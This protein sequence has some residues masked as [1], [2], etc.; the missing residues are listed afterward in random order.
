MFPSLHATPL[1][2]T[3]RVATMGEL[4]LF[5]NPLRQDHWQPP[6]AYEIQT[7]IALRPAETKPL[8]PDPR[9]SLGGLRLRT[10][11]SRVSQSDFWAKGEVRRNGRAPGDVV[12]K[13]DSDPSAICLRCTHRTTTRNGRTALTANPPS[14]REPTSS[15]PPT[16]A[17]RSCIPVVP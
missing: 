15:E 14:A 12:G 4:F 7:P 6:R 9:C 10:E 16:D 17:A 3:T 2:V 11:L 13:Q 1:P 5:G 8:H